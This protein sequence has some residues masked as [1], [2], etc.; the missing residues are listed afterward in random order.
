LSQPL[1][2]DAQG[3]AGGAAENPTQSVGE[4]ILDSMRASLDRG[5]NQIIVRLRPPELGTVLVRFRENGEQISGLLEVSR[6]DTRYEIEQMLPPVL[7]NLQEAGIQVERLEVVVSG[8]E[9]RDFAGGQPQQDA[10]L[11]QRGSSQDRDFAQSAWLA[12]NQ[13]AGESHP[14]D[15]EE[16]PRADGPP[17]GTRGRINMLL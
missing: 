10:W 8:E 14:T 15:L 4:Q 6:S 3:T 13:K 12:E 17:G 7:R 2:A 1:A 9:E 11:P 5:D 16:G